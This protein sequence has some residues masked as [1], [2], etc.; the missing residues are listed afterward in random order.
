MQKI[1][2]RSQMRFQTII[3]QTLFITTFLL[4]GCRDNV[5]STGGSFDDSL[6]V[7]VQ[8]YDR[9]QSRY[10][11]TGDFS[12][13][14]QMNTNYPIET[15]TLI[16]NVLQLGT[17]DQQDINER[18]LKFYQDSILQT[19]IT[20]AEAQYAN[21]D[22]INQALSSAI[23]QLKNEIP[24]IP[25]PTFYMQIGALDQ[26]IIVGDGVVGISLDKYLGKDYKLY[27]RW[28]PESQL[29]T[30]TRDNIV[31]DCLTFYILSHYPLMNFEHRPQPERDAHI[32]KVMW[33]VNKITNTKFYTLDYVKKTEQYMKQ[34]PDA[35]IADMLVE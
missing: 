23:K 4:T 11:T 33:L 18:F 7:R 2:K 15:R 20:D 12:A 8:R 3:I 10:L 16:E 34:H 25:V 17:V 19:I 6:T 27:K 32:G 24:T 29:Q 28:Y 31:P 35:R 5:W 1:K 21:I 9:I 26:S 30:M 14:Q 13:L 22:D